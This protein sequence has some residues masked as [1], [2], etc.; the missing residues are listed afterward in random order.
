MAGT[1]WRT[2]LR[3]AVYRGDGQA[4]IRLA[5][6][7]LQSNPTAL[8]LIGDGL[9]CALTEQIEGA[10][11]VAADCVAALAERDWAGDIEL[12]EQL[13]ALLGTGPTPMLRPLPVD[14]AELADILEGD[15]TH[16]GGL[17]DLHTGEVWPQTTIDYA[18]D[19]SGEIAGAPDEDDDPDR[20]LPVECEGSHEGY[21]DMEVFIDTLTDPNQADRLQIAIQGRGAFRR[22]KD[23]LGCTPH[24]LDRWSSFSEERQRGRARTWL[25]DAGYKPFT[26]PTTA[27]PT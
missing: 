18:H 5:R 13:Q 2:Q 10:A 1:E 4:V 6:P 14:L 12:G 7:D 27:Y 17:L 9:I 24:E 8:Q 19:N 11:E 25:A 22:F 16:G 21:H 3:G 23:I 15:P 20:W 26:A